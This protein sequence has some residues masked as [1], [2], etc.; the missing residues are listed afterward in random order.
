MGEEDTE[1]RK[2]D[3]WKEHRDRDKRRGTG[4]RDGKKRQVE[5]TQR[6][7]KKRDG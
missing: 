7:R 5:R 1:T 2:I 6:N 4:H 3:R